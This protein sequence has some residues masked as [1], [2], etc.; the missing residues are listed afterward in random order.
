LT[1]RFLANALTGYIRRMVV[2]RTGLE[3]PFDFNL[4]YAPAARGGGPAPSD[5][6]PS[7]FTAVQEQLGLK[8]EAATAPVEVLV[9]DSA[10]MPSEN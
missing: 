6:R 5:D 7:I 3:G 10:S 2:D 9:V 4:T 8:L 1:L